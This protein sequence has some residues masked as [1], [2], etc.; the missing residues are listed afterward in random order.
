MRLRRKIAYAFLTLV[1]AA[2]VWP[3]YL[4]WWAQRTAETHGCTFGMAMHTDGCVVNG[5]NIGA[6]LNAAYSNAG[7]VI[8]TM[9]VGFVIVVTLIVMV[10]KDLRRK[11][12][13]PQPKA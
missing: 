3:A 9:P 4:V 12:T 1:L 6:Q 7:L 5:E 13:A 2:C 10:S 11:H 8:L